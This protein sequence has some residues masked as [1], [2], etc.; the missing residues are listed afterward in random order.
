MHVYDYLLAALP[1]Q[2]LCFYTAYSLTVILK[3]ITN[4][5]TLVYYIDVRKYTQPISHH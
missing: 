3:V 5:P 1:W 4:Q 2:C